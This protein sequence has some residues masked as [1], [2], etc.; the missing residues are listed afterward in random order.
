M[1]LTKLIKLLTV[2]SLLQRLIKLIVLLLTVGG[3]IILL[4]ML[5]RMIRGEG[6][7]IIDLITPPLEHLGCEEY[8]YGCPINGYRCTPTMIYKCLLRGVAPQ[9]YMKYVK[10]K[11]IDS[12]NVVRYS[13]LYKNIDG[14]KLGSYVTF[15]N[16][17]EYVI[18]SLD[19]ENDQPQDCPAIRKDP[20]ETDRGIIKLIS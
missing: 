14:L 16:G 8:A 3:S 5:I 10:Y 17:Q 6:F 1:F 11:I 9:D 20:A 15:D 7:T 13:G 12:Q 4:I 18:N 19:V 2:G